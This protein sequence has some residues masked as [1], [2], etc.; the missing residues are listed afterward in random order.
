MPRAITVTLEDG[1][2]VLYKNAPDEITPDDVKARVASE[3]PGIGVSSI[4]GGAKYKAKPN[5]PPI[6]EDVAKTALPAVA[7]GA[8]NL[9]GAPADLWQLI[10]GG[11][12][13]ASG[14]LLQALG[15]ISPETK[16]KMVELAKPE[17][18]MPTGD[19]IRSLLGMRDLYEPKTPVGK[20]VGGTIEGAA[21]SPFGVPMAMLGGVSGLASEAAGQATEGSDFEKAARIVAGVAAPMGVQAARVWK[22]TPMRMIR[23]A[24]GD[25]TPAQ[26]AEAQ[27]ALDKARQQ[28]INLMAA[29]VMPPSSIQQ[30]ASDVAASRSGGQIIN[31][32]MARRPNEVKAAVQDRLLT[33]VG[34]ADTPDV[35]M[36]RAKETATAVIKNAEKARTAATAPFF[37]RARQDIA[38]QSVIDD[39]IARAEAMKGTQDV[40]NRQA[41][42]NFIAQLKATAS[43]A[44]PENNVRALYGQYQTTRKATEA[45]P[46][47]AT[48]EQRATS[49]TIGKLNQQLDQ[50]LSAA[51][52]NVQ[53]GKQLYQQMSESVVDPLN[54]G[55]VGRVAG[56]HGFDPSVPP[57]LNP[58][59]AIANSAMS[60]PESIRELYSQLNA[61]DRQAFPGIARTWLEN[62][63]DTAT[64]RVQAGENRMIGANFA[65]NVYGTD[66]QIQNFQEIMRGVATANGVKNPDAYVRGASNLMEVLQM[67]G[68]VPGIGSPTG[69][70]LPTNEMAQSSKA[71]SV[72]ESIG[73]QPLSATAKTLRAFVGQQNYKRLADILTDPDSVRKIE[74]L[75]KYSPKT[76][77]AQALAAGLLVISNAE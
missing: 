17:L 18:P 9:V 54:A 13:K 24:T 52:P 48:Q 2:T 41:I 67:T 72:M 19:N 27:Q 30:L 47:N 6:S 46:I 63:F 39:L 58:V 32:F 14:G 34:A 10:S 62:A 51:S 42:D 35:N 59:Q 3:Y 43:G 61:V 7:R 70:R 68:K 8:T 21:S 69:G 75:G 12:A 29:E 74:Q 65:K 77:T 5:L 22:D 15:V 60:R 38:P 73:T 64:Q 1:R 20:L 57:N 31:Q 55:P 50:A 33:P 53:Q 26:F 49:G 76:S 44:V 40:T 45:L 66:Q 28:G 71:A 23:E 37:E 56:V 36:A 4:D 11:A 16:K 25:M